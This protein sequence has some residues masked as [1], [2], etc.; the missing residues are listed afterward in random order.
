[1]NEGLMR[2]EHMTLT[3]RMFW[4]YLSLVVP[5]RSAPV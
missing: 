3:V 2:L 5:A 1:M 4:G